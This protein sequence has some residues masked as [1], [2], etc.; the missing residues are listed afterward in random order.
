MT[1]K[2]LRGLLI[3]DYTFVNLYDEEDGEHCDILTQYDGRDSLSY[4]YDDCRVTGI[5]SESAYGYS[6]YL[7]VELAHED[8]EKAR[9]R[10]TF[11]AREQIIWGEDFNPE[12]YLGGV[13]HFECMRLEYVKEL[14]EK[15]YLDPEDQQNFSPTAKEMIAFVEALDHS[16]DWLFEGYAVSPDREDCRVTLD[17]LYC[18]NPMDISYDDMVDFVNF[19]RLADE[20]RFDYSVQDPS[21]NA[22]GAWWD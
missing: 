18:D 7:V 12:Q 13:R 17:G 16:E 21:V 4:D 5:T 2:E 15:G 8:V 6:S 10:T 1:F 3:G 11:N 22:F 20:F 9:R 19:A 14:I